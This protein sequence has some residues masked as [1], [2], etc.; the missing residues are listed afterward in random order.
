MEQEQ[1]WSL[2][3]RA[4]T[5]DQDAFTQ[6]FERHYSFLYKYLLKLTLDEEVSADLAQDTMLK[7]Y[8]NLSSFKGKGKF[9]TWMI[10]IS[11]RLYMDL[12]RKQK[13][14]KKWLNQIKRTLSRQLT[15][16][17]KV[18]GM[19]WSDVFTDF[20]QLADEMRVPILLHHYYGYSY[21][22]VG[23][24]MGIPPGTVKSRVHTGLTRL[25]KE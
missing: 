10:S 22:E 18:K 24:M 13:R 8:T 1:D 2:I 4:R 17:A 3:E 20:N 7:C 15:W 5:G 6:L 16:Q 9:S 19:E 11:T 21:E 12:L 25:R 23:H 14:E